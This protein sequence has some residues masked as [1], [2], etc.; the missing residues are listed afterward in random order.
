MRSYAR[1]LGASPTPPWE[2]MQPHEALH[3]TGWFRWSDQ[4]KLKVLR[5]LAEDYGRDPKLRLFV[6]TNVI[7]G[8]PDRD[9]R[10]QAAAILRWVQTNVRYLNESGEQLQSPWYTIRNK[11]ADCDDMAILMGAMAYSIA[12][13]FRY[14]L[15]GRTPGP[16]AKVVRWCEGERQTF[17]GTSFY[18]IFLQLGVAGPFPAG[19]PK[20]QNWLSAEP[21]IKGLPLG[22]DVTVNGVP[23]QLR[24]MR[25]SQVPRSSSMSTPA[26]STGAGGAPSFSRFAGSRWGD[27][28]VRVA[29]TAAIAATNPLMPMGEPAFSFLR[30]STWPWG[31]IFTGSLIGAIQI[32]LSTVILNKVLSTK[33]A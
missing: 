8:V 6:A 1:Q 28:G 2:S 20:N 27:T 14:A 4:R 12:L 5:Q 33:G 22:Y 30:P 29:N 25:Q 23:P 10:G 15:A 3:L 24:E 11:V 7:R 16:S 21:T 19:G 18:H 26:R 9:Y 31:D 13:P 32:V 17:R